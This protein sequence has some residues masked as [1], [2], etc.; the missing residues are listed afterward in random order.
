MPSL[1]WVMSSLVSRSE[2][3]CWV[4]SGRTP[5]SER[6]FVGQIAV[7]PAKRRTLAR[8]SRQIRAVRGRFPASPWSWVRESEDRAADQPEAGMDE[9]DGDAA[10]GQVADQ[11][12]RPLDGNMLEDRQAD[13]HR[14]QP[15]PC[16]QGR[17][18]HPGRA[19]GSMHSAAGAPGP[20]QVM[21]IAHRR[22]RLGNVLL[23]VRSGNT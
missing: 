21:L 5:R 11:P 4:L 19:G 2:I 1:S 16:R 22:T 20:V 7:L 6:L 17:G 10:A 9:P 12:L 15:R 13:G 23:L 18:R 8:W 14:R 3:S